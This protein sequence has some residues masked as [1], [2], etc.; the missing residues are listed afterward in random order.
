MKPRVLSRSCSYPVPAPLVDEILDE[1][2]P[3]LEGKR[4]LVKPN[5]L[6]AVLP[7]R[8]VTTHPSVV[9]ALVSGLR[10]RGARVSV[11]DNP[12]ARE[13]G[14]GEHCFRV[15]GL[16]DAAGEAF[17]DFGRANVTVEVNSR[18][19]KKV[20]VSRHVMEADY[21][22]SVPKMKT[23]C[24]TLLTGGV[25]N[26]YGI[27]AGAEKAR[28]H[29]VARR[30]AAFSEALIDVYSIRPPDLAVMDAV[31]AM[32]G[33][34]PSH[35]VL[36]PIGRILASDNAVALDAVAAG[37]MGVSPAKV[38]HLAVAALRGF[39]PIE[40]SGMEVAG[41]TAAVSGFALPST[42]RLGLMT[43]LSN[44]AVF[45]MLHRSR[46]RIDGDECSGC[47]ECRAACP[48]GA[49]EE[50]DG[51]CRIDGDRCHQCFCCYE[52]CPVGA[53]KVRGALGA[54]LHRSESQGG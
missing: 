14:S 11:G 43:V 17:V 21:L 44:W 8:G 47:G 4:V 23:H 36:R 5:C 49:I 34:G 33:D 22:I 32:E 45:N 25:K 37:M 24:L 1:L 20:V 40:R 48:A 53:V 50:K 10:R 28:L 52:L 19:M 13:Y 46:I 42:F 39:G 51:V 7:E 31:V 6:T 26:M 41:E 18:F 3:S 29:Y 27:L 38:E 2:G 9:R 12:G 15:S 54:L 35:G 16:L 30:K